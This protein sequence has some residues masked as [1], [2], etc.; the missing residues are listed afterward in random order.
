VAEGIERDLASVDHFSMDGT[1]I[2]SMTSHKSINP[3][4]ATPSEC[5][6]T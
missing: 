5:W 6:G 4:S 2:R 3:I 1:L